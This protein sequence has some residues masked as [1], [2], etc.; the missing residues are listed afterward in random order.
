MKIDK[1]HT[2]PLVIREDEADLIMAQPVYGL[3]CKDQRFEKSDLITEDT[4]ALQFREGWYAPKVNGVTRIMRILKR[5]D[6]PK[7][8]EDEKGDGK[9]LVESA[10]S[11]RFVPKP[12]RD[13][14]Y[15]G[16]VNDVPR[17]A[18]AKELGTHLELTVDLTAGSGGLQGR[19]LDS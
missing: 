5:S 4:I 7:A 15:I 10:Y 8:V 14:W 17:N 1:T 3:V 6:D 13:L 2:L 16:G 11:K 12:S 19:S 18:L 9:W